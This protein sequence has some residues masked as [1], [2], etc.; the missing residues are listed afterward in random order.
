MAARK[1]VELRVFVAPTLPEVVLGDELRLRQILNNLVGNA[2]KFSAGLAHPGA[3]RIRAEADAAGQL[4]IDV[5]DN[6]IGMTPEVM[7]QLFTPF[8]QAEASTTRRYGGTGLGLAI[9][10]R[11]AALL[12]GRIEVASEYG[13]GSR[14][15]A[16]MPLVAAATGRSAAPGAALDGV[17]CFIVGR[18]AGVVRDWSTYLAH[19]GANVRVHAGL[20]A[21]RQAMA[22][23]ISAE[24]AL[25]TDMAAADDRWHALREAFAAADAGLVVVPRG[26]RRR[27]RRELERVVSVDGDAMRR[28]ALIDAVAL[29]VGRLRAAPSPR[30]PDPVPATMPVVPTVDEAVAAGRLILVAEDDPINR[31]V[32]ELQLVRLGLA[33]E[34][35]NDGVEALKRWRS[36]RHALLLTDLHMPKMDGYELTAAIRREEPAGRHIPI[37]ALTANALRGEDARCKS[38]GMDDYLSKPVL[39]DVLRETLARWLPAT[40]AAV[41]LDAAQ[42]ESAAP[43]AAALPVLD[44]TVLAGLVGDDRALIDE[45][46]QEYRVSVRAAADGI[47]SARSTSSWKQIG[48]L[49]HQLKSSS[50]SVGALALGE[51]CAALEQAGKSDR[52]EE[53]AAQLPIFEHA[54]AQVVEAIE[55]SL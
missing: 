34:F 54:L 49:A 2:I 1:K 13:V 14:F 35:G 44:T 19:A 15:T 33:C 12:G 38:A 10:Q 6:G 43:S 51:I 48:A 21:A 25:V 53:V 41:P 4:R 47:R 45:F 36:A 8:T 37:I 20:D 17:H 22:Q 52:G 11:L 28:D 7:A 50:R 46:L 9:C 26:A 27:P 29:A 39:I 32:I 42:G 16:I 30:R 55:H 40:A 18:D 23:L 3:V 31:K 24:K 5:S